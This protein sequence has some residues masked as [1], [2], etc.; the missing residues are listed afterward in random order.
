M[1]EDTTLL[2]LNGQ[3]LWF[4]TAISKVA[5]LAALPESWDGRGSRKIQPAAIENMLQVLLAVDAETVPAPHISPISGGAL[6]VEWSYK[7]HD[8]EIVTR[9]DGSVEYLKTQA[10]DGDNMQDGSLSVDDKAG[11]RD[12]IRQTSFREASVTSAPR[13]WRAK[14][15]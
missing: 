7:D 12:L 1:I 10:D 11:M 14:L 6:Q 3:S 8:L 5:A 15:K 9:S 13:Q 2:K 4:P